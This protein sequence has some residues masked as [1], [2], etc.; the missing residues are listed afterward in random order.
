MRSKR[1]RRSA[2]LTRNVLVATAI[3]AAVSGGTL[4]VTESASAT[5]THQADSCTSPINGNIG[6]P[7]TVRAE[8]LRAIVKRGA[9]E[10]GSLLALADVA[11]NDVA[12]NGSI[13]VGTVPNAQQGHVSGPAIAEATVKTLNGSLGLGLDPKKA[14]AGIKAKVAASCGL[15][16]SVNDFDAPDSPSPQPGPAPGG[17]GTAPGSG[18]LPD[19]LPSQ[20]TGSGGVHAPQRT[21]DN[22][23]VVPPGIPA[24]PPGMRYPGDSQ[25]PGMQ[26]PQMGELG[27]PGQQQ[28]PLPEY[29]NAGNADSL[30]APEV[31]S[32]VQLPMLLAVVALAGVSA[33]LVRTWVVR[34]SAA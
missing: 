15:P 19:P 7:V 1:N 23:P 29:Q 33:G 4:I 25:L 26:A 32:T 20:N 12:K 22:I 8:S 24:P 17:S 34:R 5:T 14:I 2:K 31:P 3:A 9:Q 18:N 11:A 13:R 10:S 30:A 28:A 27:A 21:Y 6:D 16:V